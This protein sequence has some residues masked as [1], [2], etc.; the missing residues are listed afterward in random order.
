MPRCLCFQ[1]SALLPGQAISYTSAAQKLGKRMKGGGLLNAW[2][3]FCSYSGS[4][5]PR[6][7]IFWSCH[8][9]RTVVG[10]NRPKLEAFSIDP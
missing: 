6:G 7:P 5:Y 2:S 9:F 4:C 1:A 3:V 10:E 8:F